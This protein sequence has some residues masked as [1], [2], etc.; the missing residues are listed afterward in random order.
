MYSIYMQDSCY[1]ALTNNSNITRAQVRC[2][3]KNKECEEVGPSSSVG[4]IDDTE[5]EGFQPAKK[6]LR[7]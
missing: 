4:E 6:M 7:S 1:L 2:Q 3:H 5:Q